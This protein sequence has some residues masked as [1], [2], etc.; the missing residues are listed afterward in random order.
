MIYRV[1]KPEVPVLWLDT[2]AITALS[3]AYEQPDSEDP[4]I[5]TN[6]RLLDRLRELRRN[7]SIFIFETDQMREIEVRSNLEDAARTVISQLSL[8]VRSSY[9]NIQDNQISKAMQ[10]S[11]DNETDVELSFASAFREDPFSQ[12]QHGAVIIGAHFEP[13]RERITAHLQ[14]SVEIAEKWE[15]IRQAADRSIPADT[16]RREQWDRELLARQNVFRNAYASLAVPENVDS[17]FNQLDSFSLP[18]M[19]WTRH[20]GQRSPVALFEFYGSDFYTSLPSVNIFAGL[21]AHKVTGNERIKPSDIADLNNIST[22]LPY[23]SH[24]VLDRAMI[25]A[26]GQLGF[27]QQYHVKLLRLNELIDEF[28]EL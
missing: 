28:S 16:S 23:C 22:V 12:E 4:A 1:A 17:Y 14:S 21:A 18:M 19:M 26:V 8:G 7:G 3:T 9:M 27:D 20:S 2:H 5:Q 25:H 10:A 24:M 13:N 15:E 6:R 11:V